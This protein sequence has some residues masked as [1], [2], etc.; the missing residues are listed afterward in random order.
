MEE[1]LCS[2]PASDLVGKR[3]TS[4]QILESNVTAGEGRDKYLVYEE[5]REDAPNPAV[6]KFVLMADSSI[7]VAVVT[8][9]IHYK[10]DF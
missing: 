3:H 4:A 10:L 1:S 6:G 2:Q 5:C 9:N 8:S 7:Q